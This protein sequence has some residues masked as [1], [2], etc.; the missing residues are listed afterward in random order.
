MGCGKFIVTWCYMCFAR[1][2]WP[3]ALLSDI[4]GPVQVSALE[5]WIMPAKQNTIRSP[6]IISSTQWS[7]TGKL[8]VESTAGGTLSHNL[9]VYD[10]L[11]CSQITPM[12]RSVIIGPPNIGLYDD[13]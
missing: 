3:S 9:Q 5:V 6:H 4:G 7:A 11:L 12:I 10:P 1:H 2:A 13:R 8:E